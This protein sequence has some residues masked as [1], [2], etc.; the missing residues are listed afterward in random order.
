MKNAASSEPQKGRGQDLH[1]TPEVEARAR[2][3]F[4]SVPESSSQADPDSRAQQNS[5]GCFK[6]LAS[7]AELLK[8]VSGGS[9]RPFSIA[10]RKLQGTCCDSS[11]WACNIA[12]VR[13]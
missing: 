11:S 5:I 1:C 2:H 6:R 4:F 13:L 12:L 9:R 7:C 10:Q 3:S 8:Y